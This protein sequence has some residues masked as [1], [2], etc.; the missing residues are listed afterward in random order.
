MAML[1][2]LEPKLAQRLI[3]TGAK[4][5]RTS[6]DIRGEVVWFFQPDDLSFDIGDAVQAGEAFFSSTMSIAF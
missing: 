3:D 1:C 6:K 5:L 2:V 4:L